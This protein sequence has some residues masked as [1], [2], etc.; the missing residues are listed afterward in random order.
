MRQPE[1]DVL[2]NV[3]YPAANAAYLIMNV[4]APPLSLPN[5]F[6][7]VGPILADPAAA[8]HAMSQAHPYQQRIA[9]A[10]VA[11]SSIL[12]LVAYNAAAK[13]AVVALR[14]TKTIW[15]WI[16]DLEASPVP[17]MPDPSAG[18][19]HMGFYLVYAHICRSIEGLLRQGGV[20]IDRLYVTGHSLGAALA[21]LCGFDIG[22]RMHIGPAPEL[23]TFAGPRTG[24]PKFASSA[25]AS[26][27][28]CERVVNFMD[29]VPQVPF[30]PLY[31]HA[32]YETLVHGGFRPLDV[33]Y[34]HHLTT[35]LAGLKQLPEA[36]VKLAA[37]P[38]LAASA[39]ASAAASQE[40]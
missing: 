2:I 4:P 12:G 31:E 25:N 6:Q 29:V 24:D 22:Q 3:M 20:T 28:V 21:I 10:T 32:G 37:A 18:F 15:E 9:N 5:G 33:T 27:K 16:D 23:Y 19:V 7:L 8:A 39:G 40:P 34:A 26:V 30:P 36:S 11:E 38:V 35:Y 17:Y 14:G 1:V 13:C